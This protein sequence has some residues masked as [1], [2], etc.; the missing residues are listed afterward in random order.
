MIDNINN[1]STERYMIPLVGV[2]ALNL[3]AYYTCQE[4]LAGSFSVWFSS[5]LSVTGSVM[6]GLPYIFA[7]ATLKMTSF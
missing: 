4:Q 2:F 1:E 6:T 3:P 7:L 5:F